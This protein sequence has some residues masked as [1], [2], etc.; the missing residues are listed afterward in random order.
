MHNPISNQLY[1]SLLGLL[2]G[3]SGSK[4]I[5]TPT[6]K[7]IFANRIRWQYKHVQGQRNCLPRF[8]LCSP[9]ERRSRRSF[10]SRTYRRCYTS[11]SSPSSAASQWCTPSTHRSKTAN[12]TATRQ[13]RAPGYRSAS[14]EI[15]PQALTAG[16][17]VATRPVSL[18]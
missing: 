7:I 18:Q 8:L 15:S 10:H 11:R 13:S 5:L 17:T 14:L 12:A 9:A 3:F 1:L 6:I 16:L 2:V 4:G